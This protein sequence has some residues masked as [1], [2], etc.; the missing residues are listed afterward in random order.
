M[1]NLR[2]ELI[3]DGGATIG[4]GPTWEPLTGRLVWVDIPEGTVHVLDPESKHDQSF[5]IGQPV[6]VAL[7]GPPNSLVVACAD[8]FYLLDSN[9]GRTDLIAEVEAKDAETRMN[10]GA[11]DALGRVWAGTMSGAS[12][13]RPGAGS[14]YRLDPEGRVTKV[15]SDLTI[16]NGIGWSPDNTRMYFID[17]PTQSVDVF[18]FD[19]Q[20]GSISNRRSLVSV[21]SDL[22]MPDGLAVDS[23]GCIWVALWGGGALHRYDSLGVLLETVR[24][25]VR[26]VSSC[27]FGGDGLDE[28]YIT[29]ARYTLSSDE[30]VGQ[31]GAGGIF[32]YKASVRG[33]AATR[34]ARSP[35]GHSIEPAGGANA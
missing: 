7:L 5:E 15:L 17:S 6:G 14:L 11:C 22:G 9:T 8:G 25:P 31:P 2:A 10:D 27:G 12:R 34:W 1:T 30:L 3:Y 35:T 18:D 32:R 23:Q 20:Q 29:T 33:K 28:L 4:E 26:F 24:L 13:P 19:L 21:P 16:S